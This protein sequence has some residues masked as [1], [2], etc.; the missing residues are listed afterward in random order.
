MEDEG[1]EVKQQIQET[2]HLVPDDP[3]LTTRPPCPMKLCE[4]LILQEPEKTEF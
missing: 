1:A 2:E 3:H 4:G